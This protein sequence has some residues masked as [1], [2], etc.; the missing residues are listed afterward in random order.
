MSD[1]P[2]IILFGKERRKLARELS[3]K[4]SRRHITAHI[5]EDLGFTGDFDNVEER[6]MGHPNAFFVFLW[7]GPWDPGRLFAKEVNLAAEK[8]PNIRHFHY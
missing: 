6:I 4:L 7:S 3:D 1:S 5:W 8:L 2:L